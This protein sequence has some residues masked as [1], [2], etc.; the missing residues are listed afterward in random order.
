VKPAG[1]RFTPPPVPAAEPLPGFRVLAVVRK[2]KYTVVRFVSGRLR[3]V[4][5]PELL[6]ARLGDWTPDRATLRYQ[7]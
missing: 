7:R 5:K 2:S 3:T 1:G 6:A 4:T